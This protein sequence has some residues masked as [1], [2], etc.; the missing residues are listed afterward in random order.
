MRI[1]RFSVTDDLRWAA[2]IALSVLGALAGCA[3]PQR[4]GNGQV[5]HRVEPTMNVGYFLYL[6]EDYVKHNGARPDGGR[7]PLVM[8]FH[9]MNPYDSGGAQIREW[10]QEA[11]RYGLIICAPELHTCN[12]FMQYPLRDPNLPYVRRDERAIITVM[13]EVC[14]LT[15]ADSTRVLST[16]WSCGGYIA[17]FMVNRYPERFSCLAVRNSNFSPDLLDPKQLPKYQDMKVAIF[18]GQNDFK[19][20]R[21]ES[22]AAAAYYAQHGFDVTARFVE[23]LGHERIPQVASVFFAAQIGIEPKSPPPLG[24][25]VMHQVSPSGAPDRTTSVPRP[26]LAAATAARTGSNAIFGEPDAVATG[27]LAPAALRP[28]EAPTVAHDPGN[29]P[30]VHATRYRPVPRTPD[31]TPPRTVPT[32][33]PTRSPDDAAVQV[34]VSTTVGVAPLWISYRVELPEKYSK[35]SSVLWTDNGRAVSTATSGY[36]VL[37][38]PGDHRLEVLVITPDDREI[39]R[40]EII[41]VLQKLTTRPAEP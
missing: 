17:H 33:T 41:T 21:D 38:D 28:T 11:D 23:G 36:I 19:V 2:L 10:Q 29:A 8:T 37:H 18:F 14:R 31:P 24:E 32:R 22:L 4:S 12:S 9:G 25:L 30:V 35:G 13:D 3:V 5:L 15:Q 26:A 16:S 7:W 34:R 1:R 40:S 27:P 39:R 6:P 20:C